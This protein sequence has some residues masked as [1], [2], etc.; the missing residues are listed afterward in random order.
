MQS[1]TSL[2]S[3]SPA[4]RTVDAL[5][6]HRWAL[7]F[8]VAGVVLSALHL[9]GL[10]SAPPGLYNDEASIGYNAWAI[11]HHGVDEHGEAWPLFFRAFGE[12]KGPVY[13]YSLAPL[14]RIL[15]LSSVLVRLPAALSGLAICLLATL[16]AWRIS[17]SRLVTMLTLL[18]AGL[19]PWLFVES[20]TAFEPILLVLLLVAA[21]WCL[22]RAESDGPWWFVGCGAALGIGVFAYTPARLY[23]GLAA[24]AIALSW[25]LTK[26]RRLA[27]LPMLPPL[28][29]A[30]AA[31][32]AWGAAH[33]GALTGRYDVIGVA[34]DH[35]SIGTLLSRIAGNYVDY[36]G[37]PFLFTHG[38][39]NLRHNTGFGGMLFIVTAPAIITGLVVCAA[40]WRDSIARVLLI[41]IMLAPLPAALTMEGTPHSLR[42]AIMLPFILLLATYGWA[43]LLPMLATRRLLGMA[44]VAAATVETGGY[45]YDLYAQWPARAVAWFDVREGDAIVRA[46]QFAAGHMVVVS[47]SLDQPYIQ[48]FFRLL[49]D[50]RTAAV[51]GLDAVGIRQ[52]PA[53]QMTDA[54]PGD[55]LVLSPDDRPPAGATALEEE[56]VTVTEPVGEVGRPDRQVV[57]LASV[58][59]R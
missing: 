50:P 23:S 11:A 1:V 20:R 44:L 51:Q 25:S 9:V 32:I 7:A 47:Q 48:A 30:Y 46:R 17:R 33:P 22:V 27:W 4:S 19:E 15:P 54:A 18:T 45:L 38:D 21:L 56:T 26:D 37:V 31:L 43:T 40:R 55:V 29:A 12:Y 2:R 13:I 6:A 42:A 39:A 36:L 24:A 35:P 10:G 8:V 52:L 58:W 16:T 53:D 41:G 34:Y 28:A 57:V 3:S 59:R 5:W 14:T 49:P